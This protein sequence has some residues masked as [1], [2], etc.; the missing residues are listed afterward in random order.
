MFLVLG[1]QYGY[2]CKVI[3]IILFKS[4]RMKMILPSSHSF[5]RASMQASPLRAAVL[6]A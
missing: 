2:I 5:W 1:C 6:C 4:I 3:S